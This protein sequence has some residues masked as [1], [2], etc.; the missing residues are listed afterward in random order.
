MP[1]KTHTEKR[2]SRGARGKSPLAEKRTPRPK[3]KIDFTVDGPTVSFSGTGDWALLRLIEAH[4]P[5]YT[6]ATDVL[7]ARKLVLEFSVP[8]LRAAG[9]GAATSSTASSANTAKPGTAEARLYLGLNL[10][11]IDPKTQAP[12]A[13]IWPGSFVRSAPLP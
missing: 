5:R 10:S 11:V 8:T 6:A 7:D 13:L 12:S 4:K 1:R 3:P 9:A 2:D